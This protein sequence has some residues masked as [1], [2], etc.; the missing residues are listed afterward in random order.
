LTRLR[1]NFH[2]LIRSMITEAVLTASRAKT[3]TAR[4]MLDWAKG[5][6]FTCDQKMSDTKGDLRALFD[7]IL[8]IFRHQGRS[9]LA[10]NQE[11]EE[12]VF[13]DFAAHYDKGNGYWKRMGEKIFGDLWG[14]DGGVDANPTCY[15]RFMIVSVKDDQL[16]QAKDC[17]RQFGWWCRAG[18]RMESLGAIALVVSPVELEM[19]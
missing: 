17:V 16:Q 14:Y 1:M 11:D 2:R 12:A 9:P 3:R 4:E 18:E 7:M 15:E 8:D 6:R 5:A 10:D 13:Y 19:R